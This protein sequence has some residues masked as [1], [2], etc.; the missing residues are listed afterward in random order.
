MGKGPFLLAHLSESWYVNVHV[1]TQ[2][3]TYTTHTN[4]RCHE[5]YAF[6]DCYSHAYQQGVNTESG[7]KCCKQKNSI[8][9]NLHNICK[10]DSL[11]NTVSFKRNKCR[12]F[13]KWDFSSKLNA[14]TRPSIPAVGCVVVSL[15][16]I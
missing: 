15:H 2:I 6:N 10:C 8:L 1:H 12:H 14:N 7:Y 13:M 16:F 5:G 9:I 11:T 4:T 3:R